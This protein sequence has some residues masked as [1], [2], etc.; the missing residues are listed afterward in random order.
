MVLAQNIGIDQCNRIESPAMNPH[1]HGKV[2]CDKG[3]ENKRWGKDSAINGV[4]ETGQL[5]KNQTGQLFHA[6]YK[7]TLKMD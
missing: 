7:N 2:I 5:Q 3:G 6:I 1:L 4:G